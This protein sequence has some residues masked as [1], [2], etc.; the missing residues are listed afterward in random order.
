MHATGQYQI[1]NERT[2]FTATSQTRNDAIF[3]N[4][5]SLTHTLVGGL[6]LSD[7][8]LIS[9]KLEFL[10]YNI[11]QFCYTYRSFKNFNM[12]AFTADL[13]IVSLVESCYLKGITHKV[14]LFNEKLLE[15][16]DKHL[17]LKTSSIKKE[18]APWPNRKLKELLTTITGIHSSNTLAK[19]IF[20][21]R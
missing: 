12:E 15:L 13:Q 21:I 2:H 14:E 9:S 10:K 19:T 18:R 8:E 16:F 7:N 17:P 6:D 5:I 1:I 11:E 3:C 4:N 20:G